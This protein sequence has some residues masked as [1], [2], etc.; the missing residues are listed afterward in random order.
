MTAAPLIALADAGKRYTKFEDAPMLVSAALRLRAR[1]TRSQLWAVRHVDLEVAPGECIGVIGRNGSG[2]STLL[3]MLAGVTAPTEG[4]VTV[5][6][7]VAPLISVGVGFHP[8]LTGRENVYVN[9]AILGLT[10]REVDARLDAIVD[11]ADIA[12]FV[13]TPVKFYSS[14]MFVRLGFAVAINV[15]PHVLLIDEVLAVGDL[16]FQM[17]CFDKMAEI[18]D[19]GATVVVV[20]HNLNAVRRMCDHTMVLHSGAQRF[21]GATAD[22]ISLY[23]QLLGEERDLEGDA[24]GEEEVRGLATVESWRLVRDRADAAAGD[25]L[26]FEATVRFA[27]PADDPI[28]AFNISTDRGYMVYGEGVPAGR[29]FAPGDATT[30]RVRVAQELVSGSYKAGLGV[31]EHDTRE[32]MASA[33]PVHFYVHGRTNAKGVTDLRAGFE[34]GA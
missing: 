25:E 23:H 34:F 27:A 28:F 22:A 20:S 32:I 24:E 18:R 8:E 31:S 21:Y 10:R 29:S 15:N 33:R 17:K 30:F 2:K 14:G 9:A 12:G 7:K 3:Q 19:S 4:R 6:G 26:C 16:A 5:R 11:F 13:D 1:T